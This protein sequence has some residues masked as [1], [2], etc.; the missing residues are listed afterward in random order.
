MAAKQTLI[1]TAADPSHMSEDCIFCQIVAGEMPSHAVYESDAAYAFLDVN[2]LARGHTVVVPK[3]HY[4]RL[5][6]MPDDVAGGLFQ[7]INEITPAVEAAVD[8]PASTVGFN[9]G[10]EAGQEIHHAHC[11]IV[12]R[13]EGDG[14][15]AI[16][17]LFDGVADVSDEEMSDL[18][19]EIRDRQ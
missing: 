2:P 8:A 1:A 5:G 7:A 15:G 14:A 3:G 17:T 6:D 12:P 11:H 4:E 10:E 18:A 16:H 19:D 13:F 9:N